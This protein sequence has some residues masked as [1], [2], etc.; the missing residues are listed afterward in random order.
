MH[1]GSLRC[2]SSNIPDILGRHALR[3][4]RLGRLGATREFHHGLLALR[5]SFSQAVLQIRRPF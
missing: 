3:S 2:F 4:G 5:F 1:P